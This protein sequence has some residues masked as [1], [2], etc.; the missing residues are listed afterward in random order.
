L[1]SLGYETVIGF[2]NVKTDTGVAF[3]VGRW[4]AYSSAGTVIPYQFDRVNNGG[5]MNVA[6]GIFTAPV[7]GLY[8]FCFTAVSLASADT[9]I[10][11]R[12][13]GNTTIGSGWAA[14]KILNMPIFVTMKLQKGTTVD[15]FL[16]I[17]SIQDSDNYPI[18]FSG[19]LLEEDLVF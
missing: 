5:H 4:S 9:A 16:K 6:T 1:L 12:L 3:H 2:N 19:I 15:T 18:H 7:T 14:S 11:L 8:H 13:D 17:G 10:H